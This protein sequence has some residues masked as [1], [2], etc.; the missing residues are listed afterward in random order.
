MTGAMPVEKPDPGFKWPVAFEQVIEAP[1]RAVWDAIAMPGNLELCHPF[2]ARNPVHDW[3]GPHSHDEVHYLSGWA[4]ERHFRRWIE[5]R[6]Y[7]LEIGR[8]GGGKSFV[9]WR[10]T[11]LDNDRC[12]LRITVYP[13]V[14]QGVP[15]AIR[16]VPH[17]FR[18]R[19]MLKQYLRSVVQG[20]EW[21]VLHGERVPR[22][23]FGKHPWFS[24]T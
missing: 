18:V 12:T 17:L 9:S 22:N 23:H 19:P 15:V 20:F 14:L 7:D 3:P 16:W 8:P 10:I 5:G 11:A 4:Y 2:C 1:A 6:G 13:H 21:Y 24:A